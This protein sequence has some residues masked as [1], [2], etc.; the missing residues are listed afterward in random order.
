MS[1]MY[2]ECER[3]P[4][5]FLCS[6]TQFCIFDD[7]SDPRETSEKIYDQSIDIER[8][9]WRQRKKNET[10]GTWIPPLIPIISPV[11]QPILLNILWPRLSAPIA[12]ALPPTTSP[13]LCRTS[14]P[15]LAGPPPNLPLPLT[16]P[17]PSKPKDALEPLIFGS[18]KLKEAD[19][20]RIRV[21]W[22]MFACSTVAREVLINI[23]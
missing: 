20:P 23:L 19:T 15:D 22:W 12:C 17:L 14:P 13:S 10:H 7:G 5:R 21:T 6:Q 18:R 11:D 1:T 8:Y 2:D 16:A 3:L 9:A 4:E